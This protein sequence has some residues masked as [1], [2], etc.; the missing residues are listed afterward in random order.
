[1]VSSHSEAAGQL[2]STSPLIL[3]ALDAI[4]LAVAVE[5]KAP[6]ATLAGRLSEAARA[7]GVKV[8]PQNH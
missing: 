7:M 8:L 2:A 1:V 5:H 3:R 4:H 6:M